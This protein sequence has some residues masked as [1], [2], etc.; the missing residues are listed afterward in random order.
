MKLNW[1]VLKALKS[2]MWFEVFQAAGLMIVYMLTALN[3]LHLHV[4]E[5]AES[6]T[7]CSCFTAANV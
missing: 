5:R 7:T 2:I 4:D 6:T 3:E 1:E